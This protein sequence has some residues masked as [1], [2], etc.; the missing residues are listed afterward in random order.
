MKDIKYRFLEDLIAKMISKAGS[1]HYASSMSALE[2][3]YPL[4]YKDYIK[5]DQFILSK[6]HAVPALYAILYDLGYI[7]DLNKFRQYDGLPGHPE[8]G[9]NGVSCSSGSLGMGISKA[10]GMAKIHPDETYHVLVG[11]GELQEGQN[12]EALL[13]LIGNK[14]DN[15]IVHVDCNAHQ[16]SGLIEH[17][18]AFID[19][20]YSSEEY[21][22]KQVKLHFT[23]WEHDNKYL[24]HPQMPEYVQ[25]VQQY[26]DYML[27][28]MENEKIIILDTDLVDDF[29]LRV[30][31]E[32]YPDRFI[33]CGISEQH[34]VSM[35]NG[36]ALSGYYPVCHTFGAFYR[37]AM[38]QIYNNYQDCLNI[39][40][41]AGFVGTPHLNIGASH[42][43]VSGEKMLSWLPD[44]LVTSD[45]QDLKHIGSKSI[46]LELMI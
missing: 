2:I 10:L 36:I 18:A 38:D 33:E 34:M 46:Y 19:M 12:W 42:E 41:V 31:K 40:Y 43:A 32:K 45:I 11:D 29:G 14:I 20:L 21:I 13:Y 39:T 23:S 44:I 15:V 26:S 7:D 30:I 22:F 5:P 4:F 37:R 3:M 27:K 8:L 17:G 28:L 6:G 16:Y 35:A 24:T 1:G 25:L 9:I